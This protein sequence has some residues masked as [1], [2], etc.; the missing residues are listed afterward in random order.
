VIYPDYAAQFPVMPGGR[1][2][3]IGAT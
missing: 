2:V 3:T 1:R